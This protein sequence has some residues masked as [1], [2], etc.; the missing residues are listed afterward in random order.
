MAKNWLN[1]ELTFQR[2]EVGGVAVALMLLGLCM[3][4]QQQGRQQQAF[5]AGCVAGFHAGGRY[6]L[7]Q[8]A[9]GQQQPQSPRIV[10]PQLPAQPQ[11]AESFTMTPY[12][13]AGGYGYGADYGVGC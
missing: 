1:D 13:N 9:Q 5:N 7:A 11:G 4:R 10:A 8:T 2:Y 12:A 6:V 3:M